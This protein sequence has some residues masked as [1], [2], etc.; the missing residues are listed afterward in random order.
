MS[1][2]LIMVIRFILKI[3]KKTTKNKIIDVKN[4][5][6]ELQKNDKNQDLV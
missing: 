2:Y 5:T 4:R 3:D 1:K 6:V